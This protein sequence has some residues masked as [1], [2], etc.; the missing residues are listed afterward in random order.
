MTEIKSI[1]VLGGGC[2]NCET[3]LSNTKEAL[4]ALG[5]EIEP[6]YITDMAFIATTG[7]MSMPALMINGKVVSQGRVC[8]PGEVEKLIRKTVNFAILSKV[9]GLTCG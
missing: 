2:K 8:K 5:M 6:D 4:H 9:D 1:K 3:L 7:A